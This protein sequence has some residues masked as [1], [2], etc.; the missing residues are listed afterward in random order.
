M[1]KEE[2]ENLKGYKEVSELIN[3]E[4]DDYSYFEVG[5]LKWNDSYGSY[6]EE[7]EEE[8]YIVEITGWNN[9]TKS[10]AFNYNVKEDKIEVELSEDSFYET[11]NY[12]YKVKYF[13]MALLE[14]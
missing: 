12:D 6:D 8:H 3:G 1:N 4:L 5:E 10:L 7:D 9:K 13:W 11:N 2:L 14:W